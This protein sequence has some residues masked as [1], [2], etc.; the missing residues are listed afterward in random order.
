MAEGRVVFDGSPASVNLR[1]PPYEFR[2][3]TLVIGV[4]EQKGVA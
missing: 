3:D 2:G 1:V 4:D